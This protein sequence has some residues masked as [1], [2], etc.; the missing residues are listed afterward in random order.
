M[1]SL[2]AVILTDQWTMS[3]FEGKQ[4]PPANAA[5]GEAIAISD[6]V[7]AVWSE[8]V[9]LICVAISPSSHNTQLIGV[10][11]RHP[12]PNQEVANLHASEDHNGLKRISFNGQGKA[13]LVASVAWNL[14]QQTLQDTVCLAG[15]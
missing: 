11:C 7:I 2:P 1:H 12:Q 9:S 15:N 6:A 4:V 10:F 5:I 8:S 3:D 13:I 14:L